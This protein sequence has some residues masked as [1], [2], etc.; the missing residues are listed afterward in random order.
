MSFSDVYGSNPPGHKGTAAPSDEQLASGNIGDY[1]NAPAI[2]WIG[3]VIALV[4]LRVAWHYA[5]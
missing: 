2:S 5:T 4:L 1:G 3:I